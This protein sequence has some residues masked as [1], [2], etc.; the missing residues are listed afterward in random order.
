MQPLG[1][2]DVYSQYQMTFQLATQTGSKRIHH[3]QKDPNFK[4][5]VYDLRKINID[6]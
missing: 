5:L 4:F 2:C 3:R 6:Q 1:D